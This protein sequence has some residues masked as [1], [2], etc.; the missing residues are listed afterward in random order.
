M[1]GIVIHGIV[2]HAKFRFGQIHTNFIEQRDPE[3][4]GFMESSNFSFGTSFDRT[5][6]KNQGFVPWLGARPVEAGFI[7]TLTAIG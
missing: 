2:D 7:Q 5:N 6:T 4:G 3:F 1:A